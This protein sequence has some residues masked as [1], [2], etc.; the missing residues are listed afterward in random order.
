L[1][2]VKKARRNKRQFLHSF[3]TTFLVGPE[4]WGQ[5][6]KISGNYSLQQQSGTVKRKGWCIN[7]VAREGLKNCKKG[8][9]TANLNTRKISF[10]NNKYQRPQLARTLIAAA[11][12]AGERLV[13]CDG[14]APGIN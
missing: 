12:A 11:A 5:T 9:E 7:K 8:E 6:G 10:T 14:G 2:G 13:W 1:E 4:S 3:L